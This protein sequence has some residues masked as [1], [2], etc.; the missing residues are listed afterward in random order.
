MFEVRLQEY[1]G[2]DTRVLLVPLL[3]RNR[4]RIM[5]TQRIK[6]LDQIKEDIKFDDYTALYELLKYL[7]HYAISEYLPKGEEK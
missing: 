2:R 3:K 1:N 4:R 5:H 7:P 6:V